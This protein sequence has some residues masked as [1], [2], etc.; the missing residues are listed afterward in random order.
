MAIPTPAEWATAFAANRH[1]PERAFT[2]A[3]VKSYLDSGTVRDCSTTILCETIW[4]AQY[5]KGEDATRRKRMV[6][7]VLKGAQDELS[8]Y[9]TRSAK[10]R[11]Y[12]GKTVYPWLWGKAAETSQP[13]PMPA[14][15]PHCGGILGE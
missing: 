5:A 7:Y 9:A 10:A 15:C 14:H 11:S 8:A 2:V 13:A 4:P 3:A 1:K 12:M 6:G